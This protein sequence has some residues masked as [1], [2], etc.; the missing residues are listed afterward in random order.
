M[1]VLTIGHSTRSLHELIELLVAAGATD[2][3]DVRAF[4]RSRRHPQF[5]IETLPEALAAAGIDYVHM[6]GLGG[7]R[8]RQ[9]GVDPSLNGYWRN[10]SFHN[11]ADYA[12]SPAFAAALAEGR[13]LA[14][15]R[16]PALMCAEALW[17][18]CHRRLITDHLL[19][20]GESVAHIIGKGR[21]EPA[22]LDPA[23]VVG[24][25]GRMTYPPDQPSLL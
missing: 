21:I 8:G 11:F 15:R 2:V 22:V 6:P 16:R 3:I 25:A 5:N 24:P 20:R 14:R 7:R 13:A 17:Q 1:P 18:N 12:L 10:Q 19:A 4:P 9:P 23:A